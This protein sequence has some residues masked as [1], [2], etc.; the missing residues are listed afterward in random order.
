LARL[1]HTPSWDNDINGQIQ[2]YDRIIMANKQGQTDTKAFLLGVYV[3]G[4]ANLD[5]AVKK[6]LHG[7]S[8]NCQQLSRRAEKQGMGNLSSEEIQLLHGYSYSVIY[9]REFRKIQK[10]LS[11]DDKTLMQMLQV[12]ND[13]I[14]PKMH[15]WDKIV[16]KQ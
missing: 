7:K 3:V 10:E 4:W 13:A 11:I 12:D 16:N 15:E 8:Y 1:G 9:F 14:I 5:I 2:I 6:A